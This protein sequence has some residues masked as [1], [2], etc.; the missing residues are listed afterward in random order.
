MRY[1][2]NLAVLQTRQNLSLLFYNNNQNKQWDEQCNK[3]VSVAAHDISA[4]SVFI[5]F[6]GVPVNESCN[7]RGFIHICK[8]YNLC[9]SEHASCRHYLLQRQWRSISCWIVGCSLC[10]SW[11]LHIQLK[12]HDFTKIDFL[13]VKTSGVL[14][15]IVSHI[16][17]WD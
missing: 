5:I 3:T 16:K 7:T 4:S 10:I 1:W 9:I 8:S 17:I 14:V 12:I 11:T 13:S 6:L 15:N 2:E